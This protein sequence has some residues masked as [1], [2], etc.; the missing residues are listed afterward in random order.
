M[1]QSKKIPN[2]ETIEAFKEVEEM[3]KHPEKFKRYSNFDD[4]LKELD[5]TEQKTKKDYGKTP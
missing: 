4:L 5:I 3:K 2:E 1:E